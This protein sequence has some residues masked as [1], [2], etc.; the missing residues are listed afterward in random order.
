MY[1]VISDSFLLEDDCWDFPG[2][3]VVKTL[4]PQCWGHGFS[5]SQGTKIPPAC[6]TA[7]TIK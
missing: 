2:G 6:L 1:A 4:C 3:P 7:Q 5:P